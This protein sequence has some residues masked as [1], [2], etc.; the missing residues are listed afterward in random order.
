M[1]RVT[2]GRRLDPAPTAVLLDLDGTMLDSAPT[3]TRALARAAADY[4]H[5]YDPEDLR[6]FVGPPVRRTLAELVPEVPVDEAVAHYRAL[7]A[8][9]MREAP[10]FAQTR[11]LL[12][13]LAATGLPLA[14]A[15]SKRET[16]AQDLLDHHGLADRFLAICG[17]GE[18]DANADKA[19]V[20]TDALGRLRT[21][22]ADTAVV[23]M[24]GDKIHDIDGAAANGLATIMVGWGYGTDDERARGLAVASDEV[25]L[26]RL[27]GADVLPG[28]RTDQV[29]VPTVG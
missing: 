26:L 4:G 29:A 20:V 15:T 5:T 6:R 24:V 7:Y 27:L 13:G 11:P 10:L 14:V 22:G 16:A 25:D 9:T 18:G 17:A 2:S 12:D 1:L 23:V 19:A 3:I 8:T 28:R 21:A